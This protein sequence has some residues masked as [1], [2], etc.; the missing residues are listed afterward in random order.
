MTRGCPA[1]VE[2]FSGRRSPLP[3]SRA[4]SRA[5]PERSRRGP[6]SA[7]AG[8]FDHSRPPRRVWR[9]RPDTVPGKHRANKEKRDLKVACPERSRRVAPSP[10][11]AY[12]LPASITHL[13]FRQQKSV[14]SSEADH[15]TIRVVEKPAVFL[16]S[17]RGFSTIPVY[18]AESGGPGPQIKTKAEGKWTIKAITKQASGSGEPPSLLP[19]ILAK[20][21][22]LKI[23]FPSE[24][25]MLQ[26][27]SNAPLK[28][29]LKSDGKVQ[30]KDHLS[31][32]EPRNW[33]K[34][35]SLMF[36]NAYRKSWD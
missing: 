10:T 35:C 12:A 29:K 7:W 26:F 2:A 32:E 11:A 20:L 22:T 34:A 21:Y 15:E 28:A 31:F 17:T 19:S 27:V 13:S 24:A 1:Q 14:I 36:A 23:Q 16:E 8:I 5:C 33:T 30:S 18:P 4:K 3:K 6:Y 9:H 25:K